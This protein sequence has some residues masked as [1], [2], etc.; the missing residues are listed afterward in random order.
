MKNT[1]TT[2]RRTKI[3]ATMGPAT[4]SDE[5]VDSLIKAG[6]DVV[7]LAVQKHAEFGTRRRKCLLGPDRKRREAAS[8]EN[9]R[10]H[11]GSYPGV[12]PNPTGRRVARVERG[13][14]H[15]YVSR[16]GPEWS[17]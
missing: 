12:P 14:G 8:D 10:S 2:Y 6:V 9:E 16:K 4:T 7:R 3:V 15:V 1:R 17:G 11:G 13:I 5:A